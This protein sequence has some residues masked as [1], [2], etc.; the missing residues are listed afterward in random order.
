MLRKMPVELDLLEAAIANIRC[1]G[2]PKRVFY[3]EHG[4]E[5]GIKTAL[6]DRFNLCERLNKTESYFSGRNNND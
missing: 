2:E 3:F 1:N 4:I 5:P 6:C